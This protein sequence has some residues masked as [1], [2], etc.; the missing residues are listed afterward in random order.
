MSGISTHIL[1]TSAGKPV[2][3]IQ[4][5]LF[6]ASQEI[7]SQLTDKDGRCP[8]LLAPGMILSAGEYRLLF[9]IGWYFPTG[10][11]TEVNV[12]FRVDDASA[13]YHVPLLIS[14]FGYSTYRGS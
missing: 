4:V 13:R 10:F 8:N 2:E 6:H 3:G 5:R 12:T 11:F 1:D 7:S 14:P 9:E